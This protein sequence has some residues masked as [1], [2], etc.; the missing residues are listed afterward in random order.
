MVLERSRGRL[1][2]SYGDRLAR[3]LTEVR[4]LQG[5]GF[6]VPTKIL[7]CV[8]I[9]EKFYN[10]GIVLQEVKFKKKIYFLVQIFL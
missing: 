7:Q 5:L 2:V 8:Q 9:G 3:L 1:N 6:K 4:Q 10:Y